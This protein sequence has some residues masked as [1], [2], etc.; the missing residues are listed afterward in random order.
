MAAVDTSRAVG[1]ASADETKYL[2]KS[3][4]GRN[5]A[6]LNRGPFDL[7]VEHTVRDEAAQPEGGIGAAACNTIGDKVL[8]ANNV[9]VDTLSIVGACPKALKKR[10]WFAAASRAKADGWI[11]RRPGCTPHVV[12]DRG[13]EGHRP[14]DPAICQHFLVDLSGRLDEGLFAFPKAAVGFMISDRAPHGLGK[15]VLD[16]LQMLFPQDGATHVHGDFPGRGI[17]FN[18]VPQTSSRGNRSDFD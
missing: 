10:L 9:R 14:R 6:V 7:G 4:A 18:A 3:P 16:P 2:F 15:A 5:D 8:S 1:P 17:F 13:L 12:G 11:L